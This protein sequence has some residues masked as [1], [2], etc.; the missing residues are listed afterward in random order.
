M[1]DIFTVG[2]SN[3]DI[4][5]FLNLLEIHK[6]AVVVDIRS[7][8]YSRFSPQYN[9]KNLET[10]LAKKAIKY[11]FEGNSLGGRI[12]DKE[13]YLGKTIPDRKKN[14]A[15][16]ID[17]NVLKTKTWFQKGIEKLIELSNKNRV[18]VMCSE[19]N[20]DRCHRKLSVGKELELR[21]LRVIHLRSK[22]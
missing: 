7:V 6:I 16:L 21:G 1:T 22:E 13:C 12:E 2:H 20:P 9:Q 5:R 19:E 18:A 11:I 15:E 3:I 10:E 14:I 8:P 17:F 4:N